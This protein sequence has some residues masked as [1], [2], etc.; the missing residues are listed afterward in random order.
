M[1]YYKYIHT[2]AVVTWATDSMMTVVKWRTL[3]TRE[4]PLITPLSVAKEIHKRT[5]HTPTRI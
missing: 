5:G 2:C 1:T 3:I 4:A